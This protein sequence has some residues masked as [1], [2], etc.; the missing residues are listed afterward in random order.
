MPQAKFV[1][2]VIVSQAGL[3]SYDCQE[4]GQRL[5]PIVPRGMFSWSG[6]AVH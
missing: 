2:P 1:L 3:R 5:K 4:H 6:R